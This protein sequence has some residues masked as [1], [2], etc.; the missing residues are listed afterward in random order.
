[1]R[2]IY[3]NY[4]KLALYVY[5]RF[6]EQKT[7]DQL[8]LRL[9]FLGNRNW[10]LRWQQI[11]SGKVYRPIFRLIIRKHT[12]SSEDDQ[13]KHF[14]V[15]TTKKHSSIVDWDSTHSNCLPVP[16]AGKLVL[17]PIPFGCCL[18]TN[19]WWRRSRIYE[20]QVSMVKRE[21]I[22]TVKTNR[23]NYRRIPIPRYSKPV[24][25]IPWE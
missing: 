24:L 14:W 13:K 8:T 22:L 15:F 1:M 19:P 23:K 9:S 11:T 5:Q 6:I 17:F 10:K 16:A 25:E 3:T 12:A 20:R 2:K 18:E 4:F 21:Q 7:S